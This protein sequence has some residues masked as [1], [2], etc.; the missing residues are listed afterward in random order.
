MTILDMKVYEWNITASEESFCTDTFLEPKWQSG[1]Q[2][3]K[4]ILKSGGAMLVVRLTLLNADCGHY[5][6]SISW[7]FVIDFLC[8]SI[9]NVSF[10]DDRLSYLIPTRL[11]VLGFQL[12]IVI[13]NPKLNQLEL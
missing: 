1:K 3:K 12:L 4:S 8:N 10:L 9:F 7:F 2:L 11:A 13:Y 6:M 5:E